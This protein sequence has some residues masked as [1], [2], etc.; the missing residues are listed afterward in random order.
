M[1]RDPPTDPLNPIQRRLLEYF[2]SL[3][4]VSIAVLLRLLLRPE[5]G[6]ELPFIT[7]FPAVFVVATFFGLGP[8]V[9]AT[10]AGVLAAFRFISGTGSPGVE[11]PALGALLFMLTGVGMGWLGEARLRAQAVARKALARA[12]DDAERAEE[13]TIRAEEEAARAEEQQLRAEERRSA[14]KTR[15]A[16]PSTRPTASSAS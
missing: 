6:A 15:R 1:E 16:A 12:R 11:V 2:L 10:V 9:A 4:A 7:L 3:A 13:E 14:P 5:F 8:A